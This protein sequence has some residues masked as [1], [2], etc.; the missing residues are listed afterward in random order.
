MA[1]DAARALALRLIDSAGS[2][3]LE[4]VTLG[5]AA[6]ASVM[7]GDF[8]RAGYIARALADSVAPHY[9]RRCSGSTNLGPATCAAGPSES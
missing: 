3:V 8:D 5:T 9:T 4:G 7:M 6:Q 2:F 1:D